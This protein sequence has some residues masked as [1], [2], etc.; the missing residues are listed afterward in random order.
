MIVGQIVDIPLTE[1]AAFRW[2]PERGQ[3]LQQL[4]TRNG[5]SISR[6]RL[7]ELT[8]GVVSASNLKKIEEGEAQSVPFTTLEA[9]A[10]ALGYTPLGL[11]QRLTD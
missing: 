6:T 10:N 8:K 3:R 11:W 5:W 1:V 4:R 9:I 7:S 2:S